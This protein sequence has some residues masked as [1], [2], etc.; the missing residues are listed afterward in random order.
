MKLLKKVNSR[1]RLSEKRVQTQALAFLQQYYSKKTSGNKV[2][3]KKEVTTTADKRADGLLVFRHWLWGRYVVSLEAKSHKTM[4]AIR[5]K[6]DPY[7]L[8]WN[9]LKVGLKLCL[10]SGA[11]L[12]LWRMDDGLFQW[13]LP[14][15]IWVGGALTYG[16]LTWR[17]H[18]HQVVDMV[19]QLL[20]YP[21]NEQ[22]LAFSTDAYSDLSK[23]EKKLLE[24]LCRFENVGILLVNTTG[25][26]KIMIKP[27]RRLKFWGSYAKYYRNVI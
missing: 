24:K 12:A 18:R 26:A 10:A 23:E 20:H 27:A 14:L 2:W 8:M 1:P 5:P 21:A 22:W 7:K 9:S 17:S 11:A 6:F 4:P 25:K 19:E 15:N 16:I 3:A 13:L